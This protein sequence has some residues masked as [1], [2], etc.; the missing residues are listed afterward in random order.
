MQKRLLE[1]LNGRVSDRPPF[2]F[3]RQ[4]GRYL[5]EYRSLREKQPDF[6]RFCYTPELVVEATLQPLRRLQPDAAILF[7]DIL[8]IA[9]A[10][11]RDV[12][13]IEGKG[14]V[15]Q[16][17]E[18]AEEVR[19]LAGR[20]I[21]EHLAP[22][23]EAVGAI[24]RTLPADTALIGFAGAPWTVALYMLEG[25]GGTDGARA[26]SWAYRD[27]ESFSLLIDVLVDATTIHLVRQI[28]AGAEV[29]QLFDSW[30]GLL[31]E[32]EFR[33]WVIEPTKEM[34]RRLRAQHPEV[35]VIGFPR[36]AGLLYEDYV[37]DVAVAAV[38][39]DAGVP[40]RW[41]KAYLQPRCCV[42][43]NLD[44]I[45]LKVGGSALDRATD[46]VLSV[47]AGGPFVFNLGHGILPDTPPEHVTR[48]ADRVRAY[49]RGGADG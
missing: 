48:V 42:Q 1:A 45:L 35:P 37:K 25:R 23:F 14:P 8:V 22:V 30:A 33:R 12:R 26:R 15:L 29:V 9:D 20:P 6:L 34:V 39:V 49:R 5:P 16:P 32:D 10:L 41:A 21:E 2:W 17:L 36:A 4:A 46:R 47:L 3:M 43:G 18:T 28:E 27:P 13:F 31:A 44:N 24:A 11:G 38:G 40:L 19:A 7:S